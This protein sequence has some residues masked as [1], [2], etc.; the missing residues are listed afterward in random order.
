MN[1]PE[2]NSASIADRVRDFYDR[3]PYPPPVTGLDGYRQQWQ[4]EVVRRADYH[5]FWSARPYHEELDI[6]VAGCGTSQAAKYALRHPS[7]RIVGIDVSATSIQ[8]TEQ[9]KRQYELT[10]LELLQLPVERVHELDQHFDK[11]IC[12]GVLHHLSDPDIGLHAL[13][14]VLRPKGA[15]HLMVYA[16]YGRTGI[17]MIQ[18]YCRRLGIGNTIEEISELAKALLALPQGHPLARLLGDVPDF[19]RKSAL[20]DALLNP[21]DR[22]Y[23]VPQLF[24]LIKGAGLTFG[25]W[26]RQAPYLEEQYAVVELFRG[27]MLRH[28]VICYCDDSPDQAQP[29]YFENYE[30]LSY[31]PH[32]LPRTISVEEKLPPGAAA[33]LI[34]Q[35]HTYPDIYLP[36]NHEEKQL[37]EAVD[38]QQSVA[39]IIGRKAPNQ[40]DRLRSFFQKLWWYDQITFDSSG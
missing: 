20:A 17:Y 34:N 16:K 2:T 9:L 39:E 30:W 37:V 32:R 5:L 24:D 27:T 29:I 33:V 19:R 31:I 10:N 36:V 6:L 7:A 13:R 25:R 26:L 15:L 28:S 1:Q 40:H 18:E 21:Q 35:S 14:D 8:E 38:G 22:A 3:H 12:T 4:D 11:I 23:T